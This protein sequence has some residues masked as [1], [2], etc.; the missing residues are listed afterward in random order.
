MIRALRAAVGNAIVWGFGFGAAAMVAFAFMGLFGMLEPGIGILDAIG[1]SV[2]I[3]IMG[4]IASFAFA[5]VIRL[6]YRR[7]NIHDIDW[8][9]FALAGAVVTGIFVPSVMYLANFLS[10]GPSVP[11]EYI[12]GDIMYSALFG[13][14]VAGASL[15]IAQRASRAAD[16]P[17]FDASIEGDEELRA[18]G[19]PAPEGATR[20]KRWFAFGRRE[21]AA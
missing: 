7:R 6:L 20:K 18:L 15:R 10:G 8:K 17:S 2:R 19:Q 1:M 14:I 13:G 11:F 3:G 9:R 12:K 16:E 21:G 5:G 4:G